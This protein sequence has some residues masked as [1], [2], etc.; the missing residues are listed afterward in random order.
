MEE[1]GDNMGGGAPSVTP[2]SFMDFVS[3]TG[4]DT[5]LPVAVVYGIILA[6]SLVI[7][8]IAAVWD[9]QIKGGMAILGSHQTQ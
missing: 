9:H 7:V 2:T 6:L 4:T 5:E 8:K 1:G 3:T